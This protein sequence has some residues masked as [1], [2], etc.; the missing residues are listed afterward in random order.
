MTSVDIKYVS[1]LHPIFTKPKRIKIIV[2]GRGSTKSTGIADY[3]AAKVSNGELWC[4]ARE[5]QNSIEESVHRTIL[6]EIERLGIHGFDDTKTSIVHMNSEGRIFYRG[7]ARNITSLKSTLSGVHGLWIEEGED[8]SENTLRV[9]TASVRLNATDTEKLLAGTTL[10][11]IDDLNELLLDSDT[12]MPEIII[13]MNRGR[14]TGAVAKKWLARAESELKRC[15]YYEDDTVMVV[16]MNYTDMPKSWFIASGLEQERLDDLDKMNDAQYNHKW[17]GDYLDEV[18]NA[19]IRGKWF[20]ACIDAHKKPNLAKMFQ[21]CGAKV[22]AYDPMDDGGDAHGYAIRHG[23]IIKRVFENR[24]G[25]IDEGCDWATDLA[26]EDEIDWFVW[27]KDGMGTGLKRQISD[28]FKGKKVDYHGF[29]GGL[30]GIGQ[31]NAEKIY[32]PVEN[33][34]QDKGK[35]DELKAYSDTFRNNRAQYY[36]ELA[37]KMYNTYKCVVRGDY[38]DPDQMISFDS[39]GIEDIE[40][41]RS[42]LCSIPLKDARNQNQLI[43][44]LGK[45]EMKALKI[46]SPNMADSIMMTMW[47]PMVRRRSGA[48]RA[49]R[50]RA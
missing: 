31:D 21:P 37:D 2:G 49:V 6:D 25:E 36:I 14:R 3:V 38:I 12:R 9:L 28:A 47:A 15:G 32:Q 30:S 5:N 41:L 22:C 4:C 46:P 20:D 40:A 16:Q 19:I 10:E 34:D 45:A 26:N 42:E 8:I 29:S 43:Q 11:S 44:I 33:E 18:D 39:K 27:D 7:L 35:E 48:K 50:K 13:T 23:S 1:R 24:K 17:H